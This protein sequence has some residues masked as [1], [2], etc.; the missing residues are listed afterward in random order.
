MQG[1][2]IRFIAGGLLLIASHYALAEP[3]LPDPAWKQGTLANGFHWQILATPQRPADRIEIRLSVRTGSLSENAQQTGYSHFLPRLALTQSGTLSAV[4]ARD[5]WQNSF[6]PEHPA[7]VA[8]TSYNF[9]QFNL[10]LPGGRNDLLKNALIWLAGLANKVIVTPD[11]IASALH[12]QDMVSSWPLNTQDGWWR[13]RLQNS[14]LVNHDPN[15]AISSPVD[16]ES[17]SQFYQQWYTP[18]SVTLTL[19]GNVDSRAISE[20]IIKTFTGLPGKRQTPAPLPTLA[21]LPDAPIIGVT[22]RQV[23]HDSLALIWDSPWQQIRDS[24]NQLCYWQEDL[25]REAIFQ[26]IQHKLQDN[27]ATKTT[28]LLFDC[29]VLFRRGQCAMTISATDNKL[30]VSLEQTARLLAEL[31]DKG[32]S[33]EDISAL[34]VQKQAELQKLFVTYAHTDTATLINQRIRSLQN[35][36]VDIAPEQYQQLRQQFL[37]GM[38]S[39][40]LN[41]SIHRQLMSNIVL[42]LFQSPTAT[43]AYDLQQLQADW[44]KIMQPASDT[45]RDIATGAAD[46][47]EKAASSVNKAS[48]GGE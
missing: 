3:L 42:V 30:K 1:K 37:D 15:A 7:P 33:N 40:K 35:Q 22:G 28:S 38:T 39:A 8:M 17:L 47:T 20:Q 46:T 6:D 32:L 12:T 13:Y 23:I 31:R 10:S 18:D 9:T 25:A 45:D 2:I 36:V 27:P 19:V 44:D 16:A 26:Y 29:Q 21:A 41:D 14:N 48:P 34:L 11:T 5:L 4:Q 24:D 43:T